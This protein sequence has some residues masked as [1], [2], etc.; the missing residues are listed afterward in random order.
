ML[1]ASGGWGRGANLRRAHV[2]RENAENNTVCEFTS[3]RTPPV[4][5]WQIPASIGWGYICVFIMI[6][7]A[8]RIFRVGVLMTGKPPSPLQLLKWIRYA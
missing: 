6:W 5:L 1:S 2:K 4:P 8:A 3:D 7:G